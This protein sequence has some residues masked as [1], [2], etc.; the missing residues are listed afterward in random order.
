MSFW[1]FWSALTEKYTDDWPSHS[2]LHYLECCAWT[3]HPC[4]NWSWFENSFQIVSEENEVKIN[5]KVRDRMGT[6][7]QLQD[8]FS[9]FFSECHEERSR[10]RMA[11]TASHALSISETE[12]LT[13]MVINVFL[14]LNCF[15]YPSS[16]AYISV[17]FLGTWIQ[18]M[19]SNWVWAHETLRARKTR[20]SVDRE[21]K[22]HSQTATISRPL[23]A[24]H[25][26]VCAEYSTPSISTKRYSLCMRIC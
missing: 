26:S 13:K 7:T 15:P 24:T 5:M 1:H 9:P 6:Y 25:F 16:C 3:S 12:R 23:N 11:K 14:L 21:K 2:C 22:K 20:T 8:F 4:K 18:C 10:K 17:Y 19:L